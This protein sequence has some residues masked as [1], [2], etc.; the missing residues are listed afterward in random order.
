MLGIQAARRTTARRGLCC[1]AAF[2]LAVAFVLAVALSKAARAV[3]YPQLFGSTEIRMDNANLPTMLP[4]WGGVIERMNET[5]E[6]FA[7]VC[8]NAPLNL[9]ELKRWTPFLSSIKTLDKMSQLKQVNDFMNN[10]P[11]LQDL[12][13]ETPLEFLHKR[14]MCRD[15][16]VAKYWSLRFLGW[17]VDELRIVVLKDLNLRVDH[18]ILVVYIDG[19]AL[20][21]DNQI[22]NQVVNAKSIVHYRPTYSINEQHLW[23]HRG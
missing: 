5:P 23:I 20:V 15:Y 6:P 7:N 3:D 16:A 12:I 2:S 17:P 8:E 10:V 9:C 21:L 13:W 19:Q 14:G 22:K 4:Q 11:Y 1:T 18:A